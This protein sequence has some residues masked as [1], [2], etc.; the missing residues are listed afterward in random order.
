M[1]A[2]YEKVLEGPIKEASTPEYLGTTLVKQETQDP[3]KRN[4]YRSFVGHAMW[5]TR[6]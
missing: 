4:E 3:M 6:R 1:I 2:N 5:Y